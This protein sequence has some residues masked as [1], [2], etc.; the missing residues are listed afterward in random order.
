M[1]ANPNILCS[2]APMLCTSIASVAAIDADNWIIAVTTL[3][4]IDM[5]VHLKKPVPLQVVPLRRKA[6]H[7]STQQHR[8]AHFAG[9]GF[10][11][12]NYPRK[13]SGLKQFPCLMDK[14]R[15]PFSPRSVSHR[16]VTLTWRR[17][18]DSIKVGSYPSGVKR[19]CVL[20]DNWMWIALMHNDIGTSYVESGQRIP[21]SSTTGTAEQVKQFRFIHH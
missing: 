19:Q 16:R 3:K 6:K 20:L 14:S 18:M 7:R 4:A 9:R 11:V 21:H 2:S 5:E 1:T 8:I 15:R 13:S 17:S 10:D 12:L